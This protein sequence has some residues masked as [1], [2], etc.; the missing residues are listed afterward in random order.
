[1]EYA[2]NPDDQPILLDFPDP[3]RNPERCCVRGE[4][5]DILH[6]EIDG[7]N[8]VFKSTIKMCA[9][10]ES[11]YREAAHALGVSVAA[12]KSRVFRAKQMLRRAVC[13]RTGARV[14]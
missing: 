2:R 13:V 10:E 7:L 3:G 9:I 6:S 12:I 1:L 14:D 8:S 11:S 5:D 4:M